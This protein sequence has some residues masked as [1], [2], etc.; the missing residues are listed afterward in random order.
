MELEKSR[1]QYKAFHSAGSNELV[2]IL[3]MTPSQ[4]KTKHL[5]I[6]KTLCQRIKF[7]NDLANEIGD[8]FYKDLCNKV[9]YEVFE[10]N[11]VNLK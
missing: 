4:R 7:F 5:A 6:L 10:A 8:S 2:S 9:T 1:T 11:S 3:K